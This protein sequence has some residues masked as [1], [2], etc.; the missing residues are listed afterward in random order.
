MGMAL[1]Q[2]SFTVVLTLH[3]RPPALN[4]HLTRRGGEFFLDCGGLTHA[5]D[6]GAADVYEELS[7]HRLRNPKRCQATTVQSAS[8]GSVRTT[9]KAVVRSANESCGAPP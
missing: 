1:P 5:L 2:E 9:V 7:I 3:V 4:E 6:H 8:R